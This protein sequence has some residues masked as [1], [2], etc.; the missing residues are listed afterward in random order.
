M[1]RRVIETVE[2]AIEENVKAKDVYEN[3]LNPSVESITEDENGKVFRMRDASEPATLGMVQYYYHLGNLY[4][5][6]A[7][8]KSN[9]S[10]VVSIISAIVSITAIIASLL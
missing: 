1:K 4:T 5:D 8:T 9:I 10:I 7:D 2:T 6:G 3:N